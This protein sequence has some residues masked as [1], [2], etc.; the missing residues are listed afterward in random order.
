MSETEFHCF[1]SEEGV[2]ALNLVLWFE[3]IVDQ[4]NTTATAQGSYRAQRKFHDMITKRKSRWGL[5][6]VAKRNCIQVSM[7]SNLM[8]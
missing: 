5:D 1:D 8:F 2:D 6:A 7:Q 3:W 4:C